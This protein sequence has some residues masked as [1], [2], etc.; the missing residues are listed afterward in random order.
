VVCPQWR[1]GQAA[2]LRCGLSEL[3]GAEK[4]IVTLG[5]EPLIT[6]ELVAVFVHHPAGARAV[7]NGRPGHPVVLGVEHVERLMS[8]T[9]D[10]GAREFLGDGPEIELG[11][12]EDRGRDVDTTEDLERMRHEARAVV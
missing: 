5:D 8:L 3:R 1:E 6:S 11:G 2:S 7:Y 12:A 9:G 10:R 4:V